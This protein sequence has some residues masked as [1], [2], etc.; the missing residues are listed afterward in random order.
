VTVFDA[1]NESREL[2]LHPDGKFYDAKDNQDTLSSESMHLSE[3]D[4]D[5]SFM[6]AYSDIPDGMMSFS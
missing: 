5:P 2:P 1:N 4:E 3:G 6:D